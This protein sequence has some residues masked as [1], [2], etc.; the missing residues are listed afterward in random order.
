MTP[1]EDRILQS[2]LRVIERSGVRIEDV[3][4]K[5]QEVGR[6]HA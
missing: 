4:V 1:M 5:H 2:I 3:P 6:Q